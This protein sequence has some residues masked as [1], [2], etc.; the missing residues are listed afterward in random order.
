MTFHIEMPHTSAECL[1]AL[2]EIVEQNKK[3]LDNTY[4]GCYAGD[5]T[6]WAVIEASDEDEARRMLPTSERSKARI[7]PVGK[8]T[9][10]QIASYHNPMSDPDL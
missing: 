4:F 8:F 9:T 10:E 1:A 5:H 7:V 6:G 2:D 3:L